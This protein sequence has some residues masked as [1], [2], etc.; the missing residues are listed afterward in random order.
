MLLAKRGTGPGED[1]PL[2]RAV[3]IDPVYVPP[4]PKV[5]KGYRNHSYIRHALVEMRGARE[6]MKDAATDFGGHKVKAISALDDAIV[7]LEKALA[8]AR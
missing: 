6:L 4:S 2:V 3:G 5:Y 1:R 7:Q 8:Y